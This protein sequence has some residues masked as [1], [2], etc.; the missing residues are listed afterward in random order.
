MTGN[1]IMDLIMSTIYNFTVFIIQQS[2][3]D[4]LLLTG[5]WGILEIMNLI[6]KKSLVLTVIVWLARLTVILV[7]L[8][9]LVKYI[10]AF[11]TYF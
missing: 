5:A 6:A 4:Y 7:L 9:I 3:R 11:L 1:P 10:F 2:I 8:G